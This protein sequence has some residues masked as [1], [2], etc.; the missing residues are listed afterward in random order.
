[1]TTIRATDGYYLLNSDQF[2]Y[3]K[4]VQRRQALNVNGALA[5]VAK[6]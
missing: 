4:D 6:A 3:T 5:W 2:N 1:M